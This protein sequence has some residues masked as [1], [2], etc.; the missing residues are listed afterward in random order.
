MVKQGGKQGSHKQHGNV[1]KSKSSDSDKKKKKVLNSDNGVKS[2]P[3]KDA[4]Q[5]EGSW[6][7][8]MSN[9]VNVNV[10]AKATPTVKKDVNVDKKPSKGLSALQATFKKKLEGAKF[11][12]INEVLYSSRG[13]KSFD[14]FQKDPKLFDIYH[15]GFR[16]QASH[17]PDNPLTIIIDWLKTKHPKAIIADL[18]AGDAELAESVTNKVHSFDLVSKNDRVVAADIA[19]L[20]LDDSTVDIAVFC[21]SLMGTNIGD[22]LSEAY[23]ILKP[24]GILKIAEV[25]SRF[26]GEA[27][28]MKKFLRV[29]KRAGFDITEKPSS[30]KMFFMLECAKSERVQD[31]NSDYSAKAC[32]YKKR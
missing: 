21:L 19:N 8:S 23:R 2:K 7:N 17:W 22:F 29:L 18:G 31:I 20:P 15:E 32:V 16:E 12:M 24:K 10:K 26:E 3:K 27:D 4:H 30:N 5:A 25:R 28:G 11:R 13:E 1:H 14:T 9:A 6:A